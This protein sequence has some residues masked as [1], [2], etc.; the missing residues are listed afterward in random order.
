MKN[1]SIPKPCSEKWE[2]MST[3]EKGRFCSVCNKCVIDFTEKKHH[4]IIEILDEKKSEKIC[5]R[6]LNHQLTSENSKILNLKIRFFKHIPIYLRNNGFALTIVSVI[7]FLTG[8]SKPKTEEFT[9]TGIIMIEED[10]I[11]KNDNY[12]IGEA[13]IEDD[14]INNTKKDS[15]TK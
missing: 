3:Q 12:M 9:T 7:V 14:S 5:G 8:C 2:S 11:P 4:E 13:V 6:F 15:V 10:S 1:V